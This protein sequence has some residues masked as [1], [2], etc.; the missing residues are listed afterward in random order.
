MK[1]IANHIKVIFL[2]LIALEQI[3]FVAGWNIT[4]NIV[5]AQ[6]VIHSMRN[7][8]WMANVTPFTRP[9]KDMVESRR[10]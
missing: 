1:V 2:R 4:D 9:T 5:I 8:K 10:S 7:R 3:G 6:E